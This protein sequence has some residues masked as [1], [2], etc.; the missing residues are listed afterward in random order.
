MTEKATI[1]PGSAARRADRRC[2][3]PRIGQPSETQFPSQPFSFSQGVPIIL[4]GDEVGR[5]Q[6]GNNNPD[7]QDNEISWYAWEDADEEL[8]E[9]CRRLIH[10]C[11]NH[12]VFSRRGWFQ[13]RAIYGTEAKDI[14]WFTMDGKQMF[15]ADWGQGF[16]KTFGVFLNGATIPNPHPRGE[17]TT[18][19]T[20]YL[21]VNTHF[22]PLRFRLPHGEWGARWESVRDAATGWDLGKAQYDPA[23]EIAL[24]GRSLRVLRAINEE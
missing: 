11:K 21:L 6:R 2:P 19:D 4:G 13:G 14:A 17:P 15:E 12:P 1:A 7:C 20:F 24:E 3:D 16:A 22:E 23:D 9:F 18:D 5:T 10:Y 8:L